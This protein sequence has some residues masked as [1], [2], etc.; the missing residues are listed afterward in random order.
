VNRPGSP[1]FAMSLRSAWRDFRPFGIAL[2][3]LGMLTVLIAACID[4]L[5]TSAVYLFVTPFH[6]YL[7]LAVLACWLVER[8][9]P[10]SRAEQLLQA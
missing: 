3:A 5:T 9:R 7:E 1:T 10:N 2:I 4:P 8:S 6:G